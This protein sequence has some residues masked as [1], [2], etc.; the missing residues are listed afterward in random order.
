MNRLSTWARGGRG[1]GGRG[2]RGRLSLWAH[3]R[4]RS[5]KIEFTSER[6]LQRYLREHPKAD[7][8]KHSVTKQERGPEEKKESELRESYASET[9]PAKREKIGGELRKQV[10]KAEAE[11]QVRRDALAGRHVFTDVPTKGLERETY[12]QHFRDGKPTPERAKV[13]EAIYSES[14][15]AAK[16]VAPG[17]RP[18]A[19]MTMGGPGS[20][21]SSALGGLE[22][23]GWGVHIDPD[24]FRTQLPEWKEATRPE[25]TYMGAAAATHEESSHIAKELTRRAMAEGKNVIVDGTGG[26]AKSFMKKVKELQN[27][28]YDVHVAYTT[29]DADEGLSRAEKRAEHSGRMVPEE[30]GRQT[31]AGIPDT[32]RQMRGVVNSFQVFDNNTP[33]K[34][35]EK[36]PPPKMIL[37]SKGGEETTHDEGMMSRFRSTHG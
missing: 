33:A 1:R 20:G 4:G 37:S 29:T 7:P 34:P 15:S 17:T 16:P 19:V 28:G 26:N 2:G 5:G 25:N 8:A 27:A 32:F 13:H 22:K 18:T 10:T 21:K 12:E 9:D 30:F 36:P 14:L 24:K 31:Y 11:R 3:G 23:S 35:G 6:A